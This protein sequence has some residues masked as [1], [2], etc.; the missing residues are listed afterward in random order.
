MYESPRI[1]AKIGESLRQPIP[2]DHKKLMSH[3]NE[4]L[5]LQ[6]ELAEATCDWLQRSYE[7]KKNMLWPRDMDKKITELDRT[8]RLNADSAIVERDYQFL[9]RLE[10]IVEMR[11]E[12]AKVLLL[13]N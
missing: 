1:I 4:L 3:I 12:I 5:T 6:P 11:L 9:L 7:T 13:G 8:I 10:K 2:L